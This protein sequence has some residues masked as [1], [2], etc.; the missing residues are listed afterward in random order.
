MWL[1]GA[2]QR[3]ARAPPIRVDSSEKVGGQ[4][5]AFDST[6]YPLAAV[7]VR[8]SVRGLWRVLPVPVC[9]LA[10]H[11][12][13]FGGSLVPADGRHGYFGW[14]EPFVGALSFVSLLS[15]VALMIVSAGGGDRVRRR[16]ARWVAPLDSSSRM[17]LVDRGV[18]LVL[19][20]AAFLYLQESIET[21]VAV[22][23][24]MPALI[25]PAHLFVLLLALAAFA[26]VVAR[27]EWW[28]RRVVARLAGRSRSA[29]RHVAL[30]RLVPVAVQG[31]CRRRSP[32]AE[33]RGLRAPPL[34]V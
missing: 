27:V 2:R 32:L 24:V 15:L 23:R 18:V 5:A 22:G 7:R 25:P 30:P 26:A 3:P 6:V 17:V 1:P 31:R 13:L 16:V 4:Q 10:G 11:V 33:R 12:V 28:C 20:S 29:G 19:S 9:A 14:Y 21:S 34:T 8:L